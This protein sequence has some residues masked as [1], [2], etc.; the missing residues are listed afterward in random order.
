MRCAKDKC[1]FSYTQSSIIRRRRHFRTITEL[2]ASDSLQQSFSIQCFSWPNYFPER[3]LS[4]QEK[5]H[6]SL[7]G[8]RSHLIPHSYRTRTNI[9]F[10]SFSYIFS[11][12][13]KSTQDSRISQEKSL[14]LQ[15]IYSASHIF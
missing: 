12:L 9:L 15:M 3:F 10:H 13:T 2:G 6:C 7:L 4:Q 8:L 5:R 14:E 11:R 1:R